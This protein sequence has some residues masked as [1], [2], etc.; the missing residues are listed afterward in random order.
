[1]PV[2]VSLYVALELSDAPGRLVS[3]VIRATA[4]HSRLVISF[5]ADVRNSW[6]EHISPVPSFVKGLRPQWSY[7]WRSGKRR[8]SWDHPATLDNE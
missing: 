5:L 1:M 7:H 6:Y 4:V 3:L 8:F 2:S